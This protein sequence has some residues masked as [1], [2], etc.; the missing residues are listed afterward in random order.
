MKI[1]GELL[2]QIGFTKVEKVSTVNRTIEVLYTLTTRYNYIT[3]DNY[4]ETYGG[5]TVKTSHTDYSI[6]DKVKTV[7]QL[8]EI[9]SRNSYEGGKKTVR[10][11]IISCLELDDFVNKICKKRESSN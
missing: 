1:T 2:E 9:V 6:Y 11:D 10:N 7:A 4:N 5:W 8:L 3:L